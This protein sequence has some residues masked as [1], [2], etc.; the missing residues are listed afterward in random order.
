MQGNGE[1]DLLKASKLILLE[2]KIS[3]MHRNGRLKLLQVSAMHRKA[4]Y[5]FHRQQNPF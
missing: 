3:P 4:E 1:I 5:S 2:N